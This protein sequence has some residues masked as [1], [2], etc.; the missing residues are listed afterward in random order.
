MIKKALLFGL[1]SLLLVTV[2]NAATSKAIF[3]FTYSPYQTG[4]VEL[5]TN[6]GN[7]VSTM[8]GWYDITGLHSASNPD[9]IVGLCGSSDSCNGGNDV[10]NDFFTFHVAPGT[11]T[12]ATIS[13]YLPNPGSGMS[14]FYCNCSSLT[15]QLWDVSTPI[16]ILQAS[17]SGQTGI[18]ND[19]ESGTFFGSVVVT[20]AD[21]GTQILVN[22]NAAGLASLNAAAG[23]DWAVGGSIYGAQSPEPGTLILLGSGILGLAGVL[24]RK[25]NL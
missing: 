8:T 17:N 12:S 20:S 24:R 2:A 10:L 9:Y 25:I 7:A 21:Q 23:G 19:L 16:G 13:A 1:M 22:L 4:D 15:Y 11:Y 6:N 3:A 5:Q 18:F 14:A